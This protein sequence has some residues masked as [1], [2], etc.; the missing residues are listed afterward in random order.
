[1]SAGASS[2][3][4]FAGAI[5]S[6]QGLGPHGS[7]IGGPGKPITVHHCER[8]ERT[9]PLDPLP[10]SWW[11]YPR[12]QLRILP[13]GRATGRPRIPCRSLRPL[14][15]GHCKPPRRPPSR[16][17]VPLQPSV[18]PRSSDLHAS[19]ERRHSPPLHGPSRPRRHIALRDGTRAP[20]HPHPAR[21]PRAVDQPIRP[22]AR[23][24]QARWPNIADQ[25]GGSWPGHHRTR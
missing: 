3:A 1:M 15:R 7:M 24:G 2:T 10:L 5:P 16:P 8:A 17:H 22:A 18:G 6:P 23:D 25:A 4:F 14:P 19:P 11:A 12:A 9:T 21:R 20:R 13:A